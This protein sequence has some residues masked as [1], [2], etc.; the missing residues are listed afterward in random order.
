MVEVHEENL[1]AVVDG[2][3]PSPFY[4]REKYE[5]GHRYVAWSNNLIQLKKVFY[6]IVSEFPEDIEILLKISFEDEPEKFD[7]YY[8]KINKADFLLIIKENELYVFSDGNHQLCV[9]N[10]VSGDYIA[11]DDHDILFIYSDLNENIE[12]LKN[13]EFEERKE[14]LILEEGHWHVRPSNSEELSD[15]LIKKL[16]LK[17]K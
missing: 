11:L 4:F 13:N 10:P 7:R 12:I 16:N 9:R 17:N 6:G 1:K 15:R 8:G 14:K 5:N 2:Y 3:N